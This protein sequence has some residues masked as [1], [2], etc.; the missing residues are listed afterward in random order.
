MTTAT[1]TP[2]SNQITSV[3]N[4]VITDVELLLGEPV[5]VILATID[6]T[7]ILTVSELA[8]IVSE[9][10]HVRFHI[11]RPSSRHVANC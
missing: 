10:V 3:L 2:I 5:D 4:G 11:L 9:L 8:I 1:V 6:G 7:A